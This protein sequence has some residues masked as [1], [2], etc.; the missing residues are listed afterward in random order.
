MLLGTPPGKT[1]LVAGCTNLCCE[2]LCNFKDRGGAAAV[3]IDSGPPADAI[4]VRADNDYMVR[5]P[6][7]RFGKYI[8]GCPDLCC[9]FSLDMHDQSPRNERYKLLAQRLC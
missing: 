4:Q 1:Q 7:R 6:A 9:G 3:V 5:V 8:A 2:H